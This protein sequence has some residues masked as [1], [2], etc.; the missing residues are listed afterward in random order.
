MK[1]TPDIRPHLLWEYRWEEVD[2]T[3]LATVVIERVVERGTPK[4][5]EE[6]LRFY[7]KE[8]ILKVG[9]CLALFAVWPRTRAIGVR[10]WLNEVP[11]RR[12]TP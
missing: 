10:G 3:R 2:F 11:F 4:E 9:N 1:A 5:W 12:A 6:I 7:G 8:E